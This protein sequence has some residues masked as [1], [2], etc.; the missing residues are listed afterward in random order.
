MDQITWI[1]QHNAEIVAYTLAVIAALTVI[2][3]GFQGFVMLLA[4]AAEITATKADDEAIARIDAWLTKAETGLAWLQKWIPTFSVN[5]AASA[6][7]ETK[8]VDKSRASIEP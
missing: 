4:R 1:V 8:R 5:R 7:L 2:V 3:H 6:L